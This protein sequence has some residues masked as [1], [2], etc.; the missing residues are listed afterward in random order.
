M[1]GLRLA[2]IAD[3]SVPV[4]TL[5]GVGYVIDV[6]PAADID[7]LEALWRELLDHHL[8]DAPHLA[9]LGPA[10]AAEDSW[11][12]RREQYLR[13]LAAS[14]TAVLVARSSGR[15]VGYAVVRVVE[16]AGSWQWGDEVG[17]LETLVVG[18]DA[19]GAGVGQGLLE[20]ARNRLAGWGIRVMTVSVVAGNE[21]ALRFY[22]REGAADYLQTLI[23]PVDGN[24]SG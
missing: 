5:P 13:W 10:R 2:G 14:R 9:A 11:R 3:A 16:V 20:A 1:A 12:V 6:L 22:R 4:G 15:L 18:S 8:R 7:R 19:R 24:R 17:V 23:M 21:G